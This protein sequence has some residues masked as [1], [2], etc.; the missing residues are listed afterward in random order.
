MKQRADLTFKHNRGLGRHGWLRLTPAYSVKL[1][2]DILREL[3]GRQV[4]IEPFSG[5]GTTAV[6][7][8]EQGSICDAFDI[9]PFLIWL[10]EAKARN[11]SADERAQLMSVARQI[12]KVVPRK[13]R[14]EHWLPPI[15]AIERWWNAGHLRTLSA[16][17]AGIGELTAGPVADL[18]KIAFSRIMI[19]WSNAAFNHQ[20]MSFKEPTDHAL[21]FDDEPA[22]LQDF[23]AW[24]DRIATDVEVPLS[25][26]ARFLHCDSRG[27]K[28]G[29]TREYTALITSPPYP[30]RMSYVRELRPYMYWHGFLS[31]GRAAGELDWQ[32]IGG[33][34]G[35][36]TSRV[37]SWTPRGLFPAAHPIHATLTQIAQH[38]E[39]LANYVHKYF[40]DMVEH[41]EALIPMLANGA[42]LFYVVGNSKFYDAV[43][44]VEELYADMMKG[45]G[46]RSVAIHKIRKRNSKKELFE[47]VVTGSH[48]KK[49]RSFVF[50][51]SARSSA[52]QVSLG[53]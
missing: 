11:Y 16:I 44:P 53:F 49:G 32:A 50:D 20:S 8:A 17:Y 25:G 40:E 28:G 7:S 5:T 9:N 4:V 23:V 12:V 36:A 35:C 1:V 52:Q 13:H 21:S 30:N 6:V 37:A 31:D 2:G 39:L 14:E 29:R 51:H 42:Q 46:L 33:T 26:A 34:W 41:F 27:L 22:I 48:G 19:D 18:L 38:S 10:G 43:L 45:A 3:D 15:S 47:F 24:T